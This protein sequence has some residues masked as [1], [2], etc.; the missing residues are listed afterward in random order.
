MSKRERESRF[1][2]IYS[3]VGDTMT[4]EKVR[5]IVKRLKC[6]YQAIKSHY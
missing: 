1:A 3:T 4:Q 5:R 2:L 6:L